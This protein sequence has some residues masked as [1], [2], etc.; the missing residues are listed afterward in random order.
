MPQSTAT[1][2]DAAPSSYLTPNRPHPSTLHSAHQLRH[3]HPFW[4]RMFHY[5]LKTALPRSSPPPHSAAAAHV[6]PQ[7]TTLH[8]AHQL[9][10]SPALQVPNVP[11]RSKDRHSTFITSI[12]QCRSTHSIHQQST[13][14]STHQHT[15]S[16]TLQVMNVPLRTQE[17]EGVHHQREC[18]RAL[19]ADR[20]GE[21]THPRG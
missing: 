18:S 2:V 12:P 19:T 6:I 9:T 21:A 14:H 8:S 10:S 7:Q 16:P 11:L 20:H 17:E 1:K 3:P 13:L 15:S 4:C 5:G